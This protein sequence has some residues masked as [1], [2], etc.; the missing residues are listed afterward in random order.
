M[1]AS[2]RAHVEELFGKIKGAA[3]ERDRQAQH[4]ATEAARLQR[5]ADD[6]RLLLAGVERLAVH[7]TRD[8]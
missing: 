5:E 4:H 6:L 3:S 2:A 1:S 7:M 8:V